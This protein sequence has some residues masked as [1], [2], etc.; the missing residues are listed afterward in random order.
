MKYREFG[1]TGWNVSEIG[2][3]AWAIGGDM[4]GTQDDNESLKALHK[5]VDLGVNFVDTAQGY[6][7]R[8]SEEVIGK[9]FKERSE[10]I[11]V[12]TKVPSLSTQWSAPYDFDVNLIFPKEYLIKQCEESLRRLQRDNV[13]VY[14]FH[15]WQLISIYR[16]NGLKR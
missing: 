11:F 8:Y 4:W 12:A 10:E 15:T 1:K 5:A 7:K 16:T 9:F 14:Q 3:G 13:D 2:F 6:G